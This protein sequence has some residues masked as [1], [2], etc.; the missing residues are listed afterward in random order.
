MAVHEDDACEAMRN[1][2][3]GEILQHVEI[4][5]RRGGEGAGEV[6]V[7]VRVAEPLQRAQTDTS[8]QPGPVS[9][10]VRLRRVAANR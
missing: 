1:E 7:V 6:E 9:H 2:A 10:G 5:A 3:I 4:D 8:P